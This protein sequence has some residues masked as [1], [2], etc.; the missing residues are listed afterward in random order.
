MKLAG[1]FGDNMILQRDK[2]NHIFGTDTAAEVTVEIE[3]GSYTG[4]TADGKFDIE[5]PAIGVRR[6]I[7]IT[8]KGSETIVL[9]NVC[10]G[11]VYM[12]AGQ[13]NME[14]PV[15]RTYDRSE[16]EIKAANYPYI[17]QYRLVPDSD[18]KPVDEYVLPDLPWTSAV[19]GEVDEMSAYGFFTFKKVYDQIDVPIGL[20]L[21]A[22]GGASIESFM[23]EEDL[24]D[25]CDELDLIEKYY[26]KG[27]LT[28]YLEESNSRCA[29]W[30]ED[31]AAVDQAVYAS[32]IPEGAEE[33]TL[34]A[35]FK[36]ITG[37]SWFYKEVTI[38]EEIN[39]DDA[40]LYCGL[41]ID[42]DITYI[43]GQEVGRTEYQYPPRKYPFAASILKKGTNLIAVRLINESSV[44]GFVDAHPYYLEADGKKIDITGEWKHIK[45]KS[46]EPFVPGRMM[47]SFPVILYNASV[48]T[49]SKV[50]IKGFF[51]YQ[52]ESNGDRWEKYDTKFK[53]MVDSW[54]EIFGKDIPIV[55]TIMPDYINV[56]S[57]DTSTV[58]FGWRE[59]QRQQQEAPSVVDKCYVVDGRDLGEQFELHPQK[60][61]ELGARAA[62]VFIE[63][64]Y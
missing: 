26:G 42:A 43:N 6:D 25:C 34:P 18:F 13:S 29:K 51:W 45:E 11:D 30:R 12:L 24:K 23:R 48:L 22:Q 56:Q 37:S 5:I 41:L 55:S 7:D 14:L 9:H 63:N 3:G 40:F 61:A 36:D 33:V 47:V 28:S 31:T 59:V 57:E 62:K 15:M 2:V 49:L 53:R 35:M 17:R 64:I 1:I 27:V 46:C 4:K 16:A 19:Q 32:A 38:D 21:N 10:F 54:R 44:G 8:I 58:P 60:K 20:I 39:G 52:G 50:S